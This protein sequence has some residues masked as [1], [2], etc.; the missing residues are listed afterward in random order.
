M[1]WPGQNLLQILQGLDVPTAFLVILLTIMVVL[2]LA[3]FLGGQKVGAWDIPKVKPRQWRWFL[4]VVA[5]L[6]LV[7]L[8]PVFPTQAPAAPC[9]HEAAAQ[10]IDHEPW[11]TTLD[12]ALSHFQDLMGDY[13]LPV[14]I[15]FD[16]DL[17]AAGVPQ[18]AFMLH[19]TGDAPKNGCQLLAEIADG[20][21]RDLAVSGE[22][23]RLAIFASCDEVFVAPQ[24]ADPP[25]GEYTPCF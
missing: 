8:V 2:T 22:N 9:L 13:E 1:T 3:P 7:L 15:R 25:E 24:D 19:R 10:L 6:W 16:D 12:T 11:Q 23:L 5:L 4:T 18:R 14:R 17:L 21:N 20:F